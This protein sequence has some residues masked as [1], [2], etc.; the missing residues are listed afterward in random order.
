MKPNKF[1]A[2]P[3]VDKCVS[4][5]TVDDFYET[6]YHICED[7]SAL[8]PNDLDE[9]YDRGYMNGV[10]DAFGKVYKVLKKNEEDC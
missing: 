7:I 6:I 4:C 5:I 2:V 10:R 8:M 9:E 3:V 1:I